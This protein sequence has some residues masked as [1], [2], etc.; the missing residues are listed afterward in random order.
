MGDGA[1]ISQEIRLPTNV[2]E[3]MVATA[4]LDELIGRVDKLEHATAHTHQATKKHHEESERGFHG[5]WETMGK[6]LKREAELT[7]GIHAMGAAGLEAH[8]HLTEFFEFIGAEAA[9]E[10]IKKI[11]EDLRATGTFDGIGHSMNRPEA[12]KLFEPRE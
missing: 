4:K 5:L 2:G 8:G 10:V 6:V 7:V 12:Q 1:P 3:V 9:L 11:G